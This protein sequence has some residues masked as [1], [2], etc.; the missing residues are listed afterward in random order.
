MGEQL[1]SWQERGG[2]SRGIGA[3]SDGNLTPG[4]NPEHVETELWGP[5]VAQRHFRLNGGRKGR[6]CAGRHPGGF[7]VGQKKVSS[8][9]TPF[10]RLC[11]ADPLTGRLRGDWTS[12]WLWV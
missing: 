1:H 11:R 5:G 2:S 4:G 9:C 6:D 3:V 10:R 12:T 7:P 8:L